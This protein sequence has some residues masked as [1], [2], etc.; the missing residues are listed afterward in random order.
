[1]ASLAHPDTL[2]SG[3]PE[4]DFGI[5]TDDVFLLGEAKWRSPLGEAQGVHRD[6][7]QLTLRREFCQKYGPRLVPASAISPCWP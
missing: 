6:K 7:D 5:H 2:V 4:I 3:G 1:M